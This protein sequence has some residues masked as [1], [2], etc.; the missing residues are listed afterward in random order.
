M[1]TRSGKPPRWSKWTL[2]TA[3]L[4]TVP[5]P[6]FL[7]VVLG[8]VPTVCIIFQAVYGFLVAV[9]KW[10][11]E[12]F[13]ILGILGAHV[14]IFGGLLYAGAVS[15][16]WLFFRLMPV[17]YARLALVAVI[18]GLLVMAMFDIYR[19]PSHGM[20]APVNLPRMLQ[21]CGT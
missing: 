9:P 14:V 8:F 13:W 19:E 17:R 21:K 15:C 11:A 5:V 3:L 4:L 6:Y 7:V 10:S 1:N 16:T 12:G 2:F 20:A 18:V